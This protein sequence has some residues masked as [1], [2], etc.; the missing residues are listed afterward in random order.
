MTPFKLLSYTVNISCSEKKI[1]YISWGCNRL[2]F[3]FFH[4]I[5]SGISYSKG[6]LLASVILYD[7][8]IYSVC[9]ILLSFPI[10]TH[11]SVNNSPSISFQNITSQLLYFTKCEKPNY[12]NNKNNTNNGKNTY[13]KTL[14]INI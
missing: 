2:R 4:D 8:S 10:C 9:F 13:R 3:V 7:Y 14:D 1:I 5:F 11:N 6:N 12:N